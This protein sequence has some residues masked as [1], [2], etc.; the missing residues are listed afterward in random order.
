MAS[1]SS[2]I[3]PTPYISANCPV[4]TGKGKYKVSLHVEVLEHQ[5]YQK[6]QNKFETKTVL[7]LK[8]KG[9]GRSSPTED[10]ECISNLFDYFNQVTQSCPPT[11]EY[12]S[13]LNMV[14]GEPHLEIKMKGELNDEVPEYSIAPLWNRRLKKFQPRFC[15]A[16]VQV[17][18]D[19]NLVLVLRSPYASE[20][21]FKGKLYYSMN[22]DVDTLAFA[23]SNSKRNCR[24]EFQE[25]EED[26]TQAASQLAESVGA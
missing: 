7:L 2:K 3:Q 6:E 19:L 18:S 5:I 26:W 8:G 15:P 1:A 21:E 14:Q 23:S 22:I 17:G 4:A 13:K 16:D 25:Q 24:R 9:G 20:K 12:S 10:E 11:H